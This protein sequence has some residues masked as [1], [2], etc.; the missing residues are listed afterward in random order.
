MLPKG[1]LSLGFL[2]GMIIA[3]VTPNAHPLRARDYFTLNAY[4]FALS[5]MWNAMAQTVLPTLV[6]GL[7][8]DPQK[9]VRSAHCPSWVC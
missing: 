7:V 2:R 3:M 9:G 1:Y 5:F 6:A 4:W 8:P